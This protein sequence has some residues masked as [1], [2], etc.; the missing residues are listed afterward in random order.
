LREDATL[1]E[2]GSGESIAEM[3]RVEARERERVVVIWGEWYHGGAVEG[4]KRGRV[5]GGVIGGRG[6]P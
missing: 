2:V 4:K 1:D 5:G 3:R 6:K